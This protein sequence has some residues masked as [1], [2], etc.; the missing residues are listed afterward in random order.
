V[1]GHFQLI[2]E[3]DYYEEK[4]RM[5][6]YYADLQERRAQALAAGVPADLLIGLDDLPF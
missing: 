3:M 5:R 2:D 6:A 1:R 4:D